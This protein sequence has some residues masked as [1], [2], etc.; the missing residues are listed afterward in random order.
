MASE[1]IIEQVPRQHREPF[2]AA[3]LD[4]YVDTRGLGG[5]SKTDLDALIVY[6]YV[7]H[8]LG[9]EFDA[10]KVAQAM[11]L[12]ESRAKSLYETGLI[13]HGNLSEGAA[14]SEILVLLARTAYELESIE[15]GQIRFHFG[16]PALFRYFQVR[17]RQVERTATYSAAYETVVIGLESFLLVLDNVYE[18]SQSDFKTT[19]MDKVR[20]LVKPVIQKLGESLG[21]KRIKELTSGAKSKSAAAQALE[22]G[23]R[24]ASIGSFVKAA[25]TLGSIV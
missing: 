22:T 3:L 16:N 8:A 1:P 13:K 12:K 18:Q 20:P 23:A 6:L 19:E 14:W 21:K 5:L 4:A 24:L 17:L 25:L 2:L 15:R 10:Y 7:K 11:M 9:G